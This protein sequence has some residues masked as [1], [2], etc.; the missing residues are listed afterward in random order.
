MKR[1]INTL[2]LL[3][4]AM[5]AM[6]QTSFV[7][8]DK[9][10][11]SQFVQGLIFQQQQNAD[12]FTWKSNGSATGDIKDLLFIA[13]AKAELATANTEDVTKMLEELSGTDLADAEA[14]ATALKT[15]PNVEEAYTEDGNNVCVKTDSEDGYVMYPMYEMA[16]PF[17]EGSIDFL[18]TEEMSKTVSSVTRASTGKRGRVAIFNYFDGQREQESFLQQNI[19]VGY[20]RSKFKNHDYEVEYFGSKNEDDEKIFTQENFDNVIS[21]SSRYQAI[22]IM[23]HG[24]LGEYGKSYIATRDTPLNDRKAFSFEDPYEKKKRFRMIPVEESLRDVSGDCI[25]Y[26]G[27]CCG[28]PKGGF[29]NHAI[30]F[31][32]N[33]K[34]C[35]IA[36]E[37][38]NCIAQAHAALFFHYLLY[39]GWDVA[40]ALSALPEK[41]PKYYESQRHFSQY[42]GSKRLEG[43][44]EL[45]PQFARSVTADITAEQQYIHKKDDYND[46]QKKLR[47]KYRIKSEKYP[48]ACR[49]FF[50]NIITGY[51][52]K[53]EFIVIRSNEENELIYDMSNVYDGCHDITLETRIQPGNWKRVSLDSPAPVLVSHNFHKMYALPE[54]A[55]DQFAPSILDNGGQPT[56]EITVAAGSNKTF[57]IDGY[58]G[59]SFRA[60][61][62]EDDIAT[63][64]V[65]GSSLTVTGIAEGTTYIGVQD[66]QN[67]KIAVAEV[68][69]TAGGGA[70]YTSCP[71]SHHPHMIDLGLPSG[72]KWACCNVGASKPEDYGGYYAWGE[73]EDKYCYEWSTYIHCDNGDY[74]T[75]HDIG[76]D[77]SGTKYDAATAIWGSSWVMPNKEQM[78][79]LINNCTSEWTTENNVSGCRFTGSNGVSIFLPAA[80]RWQGTTYVEGGGNYWSSSQDESE[81]IA[82]YYL[83]CYDG[84]L[85]CN[86]EYGSRVCG[87]SVRPVV[88]GSPR[89]SSCPDDHHPHLIDLGL[90]SGTKW[91][92]CNVGAQKPEDYGGY[93]AWGET[94]TKSS[95]TWENYAYYNSSTYIGS[96]ISGTQYDAATANWGS[97]WVMPNMEQMEE[98]VDNCTSEW[99]TENGVNGLRFTGSNGAS[100]FLP[101]AGERWYDDLSL[102]G[103]YGGYWSSMLNE[104]DT[105]CGWLWYLYFESGYVDAYADAGGVG[106]SVRPV[107]K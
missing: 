21:Q 84:V 15:N 57:E 93:F 61:S 1:I 25:I 29:V 100:I 47:I 30:A 37:G 38:R 50:K 44:P 97:P 17:E 59:H 86:S 102:A 79:E 43:N 63:V 9:N 81:P 94:K 34:S 92:C 95:Y 11:N 87:L 13:R 46:R 105:D 77:I 31:P 98:L 6:A 35:A 53:K 18:S 52:H 42:G 83:D 64:S 28:V 12:R 99:I 16:N 4:V 20:I 66:L 33:T 14:I 68:N 74:L 49:L 62:L 103:S 80:G 56:E 27:A 36:W 106:R 73:T 89:L 85:D 71:D 51:I 65:S 32:N 104:W 7:V 75:C 39:D 76:S 41:D 22:I 24:G 90:P 101:A 78:E 10:G 48:V 69:V 107:V 23:S 19:L 8:T 26:I 82:A 2:F 88:G 72:T 55:D 54:I 67:R 96:D 5:M 45:R 3:S 40:Q 58:K 60:I 70:S 91:A